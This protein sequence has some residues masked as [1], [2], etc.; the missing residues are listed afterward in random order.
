M[1]SEDEYLYKY[2]DTITAESIMHER[3]EKIRAGEY[4]PDTCLFATMYCD[5]AV[6]E[7]IA[8]CKKND[9]TSKTV[10]IVKTINEHGNY[11]MVLVRVK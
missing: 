9:L 11:D 1:S 7:A 5:E 4:K 8:Y 2:G 6:E 10:K 3:F